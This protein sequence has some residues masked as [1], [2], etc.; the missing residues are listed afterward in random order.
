MTRAFPVPLIVFMLIWPEMLTHVI[1][2]GSSIDEVYADSHRQYTVV[3]DNVGKIAENALGRIAQRA[4][5]PGRGRQTLVFNP[6]A[7]EHRG[8]VAVPPGAEF[9]DGM[10]AVAPD[11]SASPVQAGCD[12]LAR[13]IA[14]APS[15]GYAV[16]RFQPS[17]SR[18]PSIA[19]SACRMENSCLRLD[20]D[21][22]GRLRR[23]YDKIARRDALAPGAVGNRFVL[24]E[25]KPVSAGQAWEIDVYYSEKPLATDGRFV[26]ARVVESG[27]VRAAVRFKRLIGKSVITQDVVLE[28]GSRRIDFVTTVEWG[29]EK[30]VLLKVAFPVNVRSDK[31]RYEIQFGSVERPTHRNR[32]QDLAMFEV[33]AQKWADLSEGDYGVALLND[34][35]YG[36]DVRDNVMRL[37]LLRAPKYPGEN[38]DVNRTHRFVYAILPHSGTHVNGVVRAGYELNV[39][40]ISRA[41]GR[42]N[43]RRRQAGSVQRDGSI[44]RQYRHRHRQ[45]GRGRRR[46]DRAALRGS[47]L[48][49]SAHLLDGPA[50]QAHF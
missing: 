29:D 40:L 25:D 4:G 17:S 14:R 26:S 47:R 42:G 28:A 33:P 9:T 37:S 16:Y 31:A 11:G 46:L 21:A 5:V 13:F 36:Y 3:L 35:K 6:L 23:I 41:Q 45:A 12:G 24:F 22:Q 30:D 38:T 49:R 43:S 8:I 19:A 27:P 20:F 15:M 39:P 34:C 2:P 7:W 32:P 44:G 50:G 18:A 1:L 48:P 10:L